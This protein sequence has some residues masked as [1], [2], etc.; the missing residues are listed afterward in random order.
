MV[1]RLA[2]GAAVDRYES[3]RQRHT[4]VINFLGTTKDKRVEDESRSVGAATVKYGQEGEEEEYDY[5][6]DEDYYEDGMS[7]DYEPRGKAVIFVVFSEI[8]LLKWQ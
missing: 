5:Y 1:S 3:D 4:A 7:G 8:V 2:S 6:E